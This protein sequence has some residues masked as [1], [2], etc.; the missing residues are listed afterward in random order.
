M[1]LLCLH[2]IIKLLAQTNIYNLMKRKHGPQLLFDVRKL[3]TF[4]LKIVKLNLDILFMESCIRGNLVPT[5][6]KVNSN[7]V[8]SD[9][10]LSKK[11]THLI[12]GRSFK[13]TINVQ[14]ISTPLL[15]FSWFYY[16][17]YFYSIHTWIFV[18]YLHFP[19]IVFFSFT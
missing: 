10:K 4:K 14:G 13:P 9:V 16:I 17:L 2:F 1:K 5:F 18:F 8:K 12:L 11:I 6:A 3:E 15:L 7:I 19:L